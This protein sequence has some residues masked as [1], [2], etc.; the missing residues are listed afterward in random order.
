MPVLVLT[1]AV[2]PIADPIMR[3][4][5]ADVVATLVIFG[6]SYAYDN[7][8][9]YDAYWSVIPPAIAVYWVMLAEPTVPALRTNGLLLVIFLW[10]IRLTW[11]WA[12]GWT[13]LDH[14]DWRYVDFRT[15]FPRAYW[16]V[17]LGGIHFLPTL[18]V[19]AGLVLAWP[20]PPEPLTA[21]AV[22]L[23]SPESDSP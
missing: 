9:F 1:I 10:G 18:T 8:S 3:T 14:E 13:G 15:Q 7:S 19:L 22:T 21:S 20:A 23:T 4:L 5:A 17:S 2:A 11:N 12:R 16:L 6:W